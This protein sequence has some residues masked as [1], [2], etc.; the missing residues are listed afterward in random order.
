MAEQN[1][2]EAERD[3]ESLVAEGRIC[4][5][6]KDYW[7]NDSVMGPYSSCDHSKPEPVSPEWIARAAEECAHEILDESYKMGTTVKAKKMC[8]DIDIAWIGTERIKA[9]IQAAIER[10]SK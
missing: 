7:G 3:Y 5:E 9:I 1:K 8:H 10:N 6:H 4:P 2:Q